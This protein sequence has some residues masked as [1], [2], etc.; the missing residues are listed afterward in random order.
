MAKFPEF[1]QQFQKF[2]AARPELTAF[3]HDPTKR[4]HSGRVLAS[5]LDERKLRR[6]L[7]TMLDEKEFFSPY[8]IRALSRRCRTLSA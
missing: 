4:G 7:A 3:I 2:V 6:V 5:I 8:G 1:Q